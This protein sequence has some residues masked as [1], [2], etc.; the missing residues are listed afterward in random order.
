MAA[1]Q[2]II[3]HGPNTI[4]NTLMAVSL[5]DES[6]ESQLDSNNSQAGATAIPEIE[7]GKVTY[8]VTKNEQNITVSAE[9]VLKQ[10]LNLLKRKYCFFFT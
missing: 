5:S 7:N 1:K 6:S 8:T 10:I 4:Q 2:G 3:R 9:S